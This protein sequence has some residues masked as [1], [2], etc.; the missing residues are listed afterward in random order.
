VG[1]E[2]LSETQSYGQAIHHCDISK[3]AARMLLMLILSMYRKDMINQA[4]RRAY[5]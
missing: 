2:L 3:V 5:P 4:A 1:F